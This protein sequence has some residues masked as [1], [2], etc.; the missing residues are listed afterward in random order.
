M[1]ML[2]KIEKIEPQLCFDIEVE[3][4][5]CFFA[6]G[7]LV[8]NSN[9]GIVR[10]VGG[11][12]EDIYFQSRERILSLESDNASFW[13][14]GN[15][16]RAEL[17]DM[18]NRI[19]KACP[20]KT[21]YI[22]VFGE[23]AGGSIQSGVGLTGLDKFFMVF[24]IRV[25]EDAECTDWEPKVVYD[26]VF[27]FEV[28]PSV[29]DKYFFKTW[30]IEIDFSNPALMQNELVRITQEVE[31]DCPVARY[32]KPDAEIGC[33]IGEGVVWV[34]EEGQDCGFDVSSVM[35]KIKGAKHSVSKVKTVAE[36]DV[37][38]VKSIADFIEYAATENRLE[39]MFQKAVELQLEISAKSTGAYIKLVVGDILK[40]ELDVMAAS[41]IEPK[42]IGGPL[43]T[44]AR[45]FW[46]KKVEESVNLG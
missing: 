20:G 22:Q 43:A 3:D 16:I 18:F 36:V 35:M 6:N 34:V 2:I 32:F 5:N 25:S 46:F 41:Q 14:W 37:E 28:H 21:G 19:E 24:G 26:E 45:E 33:L 40:E 30:K 29:F 38:K 15:S 42:D 9:G 8:H 1:T 12:A 31:A 17:N 39:Q 27:K 7:I 4:T 13:F 23:W 44:K 10:K 11:T